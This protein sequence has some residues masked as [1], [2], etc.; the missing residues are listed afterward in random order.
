MVTRAAHAMGRVIDGA[1]FNPD[2]EYHRKFA[3]IALAAA[4]TGGS[5][6]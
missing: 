5:P 6:R 4:L 2:S 1:H 3:R